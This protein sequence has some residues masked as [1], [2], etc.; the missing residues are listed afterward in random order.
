MILKALKTNKLLTI[1][2]QNNGFVQ[3]V[4]GYIQ[5]LNLFEQT[6]L[7]KDENQHV[8]SL[9]LSSIKNIY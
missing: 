6:L 4:K 5:N 3:T 2:Y 8:R 7:L 1:N 9:R